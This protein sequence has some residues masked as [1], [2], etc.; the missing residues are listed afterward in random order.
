V[1]GAW[2]CEPGG[3]AG[4]HKEELVESD[5]YDGYDYNRQ[6]MP[7]LLMAQSWQATIILGTVTLILGLIVSF[8]PSGSLNVIAVLLGVLA[9]ISGIFNLIRIFGHGES[10]RVLLG[11]TG[12]LFIVIGVVLIRHLQ[13]TLVLIGLYVGIAWIVQGVT[14]L[15]ASFAAGTGE[16]SGWWAVFGAVSL[17]AGI[18]VT[19]APV[20]SITVLA[21]L[22]GV[23]FV[24]LGVAEVFGGLMLRRAATSA[25]GND[26][27][28][29]AVWAPSG[30]G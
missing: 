2:S 5:G 10:H 14:A 18:A 12:L 9:I 26:G 24:V 15:I 16:G 6:L 7:G 8:H 20:S 30:T 28:K 1:P 27:R 3:Y 13:L 29:A 21:V 25:K 23:W 22:L 4:E 19:A 17:I 11:I